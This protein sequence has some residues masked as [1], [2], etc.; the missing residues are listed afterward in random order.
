MRAI[1]WVD[2]PEYY[3]Y[4]APRQP[5]LAGDNEA[6][7]HLYD[8]ERD[9]VRGLRGLDGFERLWLLTE[10]HLGQTWSL[11]ARPPREGMGK[12][13]VYGTRSPYRPNRLG[14]TCV[15]LLAIRG[16]TLLVRG[17]DLLHRTPVL[18]IKPY[19]PYADAFPEA[20]AGWVDERDEQRRDVR[21]T[22]VAAA[23]A[24]FIEQRAGLSARS[25]LRAQ[26]GSDPTDGR[27]KRITQ[28][29]P[30]A[31][32]QL[33][34]WQIAY[35]TWRFRYRLEAD[36]VHVVDASSG[37]SAAELADPADK[38]GDKPAHRAFRAQFP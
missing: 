23:K 21:L 15:E 30:A 5:G 32:G 12:L 22:P 34:L 20:R 1:G 27:R 4:D 35:R 37:Y 2:C 19:L 11:F 18:D 6:R 25:F 31:P 8:D 7:V 3:V 13:G 33:P 26:L 16:R 36:V 9:L 38:H 28:L 17:H 14:L 24:D 29:R 10:L